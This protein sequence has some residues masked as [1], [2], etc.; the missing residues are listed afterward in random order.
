MNFEEIASTIV[1]LLI[2]AVAGGS[3]LAGLL[4]G[5]VKGKSDGV[6]WATDMLREGLKRKE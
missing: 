4:V 2:V 3:F 1:C 6:S 5:L